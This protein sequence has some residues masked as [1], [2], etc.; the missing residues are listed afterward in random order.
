MLF[1]LLRRFPFSFLP[2]PPFSCR[3]IL[4][5]SVGAA[6]VVCR[7]AS[8]SIVKAITPYALFDTF[9]LTHRTITGIH[10]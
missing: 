8:P 6:V 3:R 10:P 2:L 1:P 5:A 7:A 4:A 9:M